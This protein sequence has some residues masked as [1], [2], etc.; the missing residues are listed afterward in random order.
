L[1]LN[2][3]KPPHFCDGTGTLLKK[4]WYNNLNTKV[5]VILY[6]RQF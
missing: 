5:R 2:I 4:I 3:K 6:D 1:I